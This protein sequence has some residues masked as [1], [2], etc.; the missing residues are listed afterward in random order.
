M[1]CA[2]KNR[3]PPSSIALHSERRPG[4][5]AIMQGGYGQPQMQQPQQQQ[6]Q[7]QA[8]APA[9]G[10]P[11]M[12]TGQTVM[13]VPLEPGER[14]IWFKKHGYLLEKIIMI[15]LGVFLLIVVVG[16]GLIIYG[17]L[18]DRWKPKAHALTNRRL[19][20]IDGKGVVTSYYFAQLADFDVE[21]QKQS[22]GG[23]LM[24]AAIGA[25]ATAAQNYVANQNTKL[26][27]KFWTKA[28]AILITYQN[29]TKVKCPVDP[30][31]GPDLGLLCARAFFG[32]EA[33]SLPPIN[34]YLP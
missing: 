18:L 10:A 24:G 27:R 16:I 12:G 17:A 14:V 9:G 23:G 7:Q 29:G 30:D 28:V 34:D 1:K 2:L 21:R 25:L 3:A 33:E 31:Y 22:G 6:Q 19:I 32:R 26:E 11:A 13:G 20:Y 8:M 4:S 15:T 5:F